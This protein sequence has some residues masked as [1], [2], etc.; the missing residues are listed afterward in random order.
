MNNRNNNVDKV[1]GEYQ[2]VI[3]AL[4]EECHRESNLKDEALSR[5]RNFTKI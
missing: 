2:H 1:E 5:F 4:S 3:T